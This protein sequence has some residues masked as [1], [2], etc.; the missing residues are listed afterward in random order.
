MPS[1]LIIVFALQVAIYL[2][3]TFG[4]ATINSLLWNIY[5]RLPTPTSQSAAEQRVLKNQF[6]KIRK[7]LNSTSSQDEFAKWAKLRRQHDKILEK[8]EKSK[9][10][11]DSTK[12]NFDKI[13]GALRWAGT[14]GF[15]MFLQFWYQKEPMFWIPKGW[16]PYYAEWLLSFP[17][18][19]LGSISIQ[20]WAL[21][22]MAIIVLVS[23]TLVALVALALG[24]RSTVNKENG[25]SMKVPSGEKQTPSQSQAEK[26]EL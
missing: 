18:A 7:E 26:K 24:T 12:A 25:E 4:A 8:L 13:V 14:N 23:D 11:L 19:P 5:N 21:A 10:E 15:R 9:A 6:M 2:I 17:R 16:V 22:C 3:N 1:L 20:A